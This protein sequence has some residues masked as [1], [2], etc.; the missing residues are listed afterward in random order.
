[1]TRWMSLSALALA[2]LIAAPGLGQQKA[3]KKGDNA[4]KGKEA[5]PVLT[6][7]AQAAK[8]PARALAYR[9]LPDPNDATEGNAAPVWVRAYLAA[10][11]VQHKWTQ[12][13][14][15]W[16]G[17]GR[18]ATRELPRQE[19]RDV[20]AKY[21]GALR[22]A[23]Q[24]ARRA[25]CD[26][27]R[28]PLTVQNLQD[29]LWL[30][31]DEIQGMRELARL[32]NLRCRVDLSE[33]KFEEAARGL[34]TGLALARHLNTGELMIQDLVAVAIASIMLSRVEEWVEQPGSPN[35]Y[36]ALTDLPR[37]LVDARKSIKHELNTIHRSFPALRELKKKK[38]TAA[39]ATRLLDQVFGASGDATEQL[40]FMGKQTTAELIKREQA[41]AKKAL[42]A[43]G[44]AE[45][46]VD[47]LPAAQVVALAFI[48]GYDRTRDEVI[49]WLAV[50]AWQGLE[51]LEKVTKDR[52]RDKEGSNLFL[53]LLLPTITKTYE[54]HLRAE[55]NVAGLR[56]AE[57]LRQHVADTGKLPAKWADV[58]APG[59]I[60]PFTGKGLDAYYSVKD[61][62]AVLHVPPPPGMPELLGRRFEMVVKGK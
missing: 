41:K 26:W 33:G 32:I 60:D 20:L 16:G 54:A 59:P 53:A 25:R 12:R 24:A 29:P 42:I 9:L 8:K 58:D 3:K 39:E 34:Q 36:W 38:V 7:A 52:A 40:P 62:K 18:T 2:A 23:D 11:S 56:G 46:D 43:G 30:P 15:D 19:V 55:R 22:L 44:R 61:G 6:L 50:P 17:H 5:P 51:K 28:G 21:A 48:E 27:D 4:A 10:R 31:L 57:A 47:A 13:Q 1:M 35:L 37:P 45:K 49:K 14:H